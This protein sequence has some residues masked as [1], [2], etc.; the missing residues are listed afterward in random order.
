[1]KRKGCTC[2]YTSAK[3]DEL[4][5]RFKQL[6]KEARV[7][8]LDRIF[9]QVAESPSSRFFISEIRAYELV[10]ERRRSGDWGIA[11]PLRRE[12]MD[13]I[14]S[15]AEKILRR[16]EESSLRNA[17]YL[18]VNTPAP[19][20]Y[21]TPRSCRTIIYNAMSVRCRLARGKSTINP[22]SKTL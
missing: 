20:F 19:R 22:L 21:L 15:R 17:V 10:S 18:A 3:N 13:E 14:L 2:D 8:D 7:V 5:K 1:M 12:M 9:A 6:I 11:N 4:V 16:G